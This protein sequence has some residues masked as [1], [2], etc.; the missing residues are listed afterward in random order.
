M[1]PVGPSGAEEAVPGP[2]RAL[3]L[4]AVVLPTLGAL[5]AALVVVGGAWREQQESRREALDAQLAYEANSISLKIRDRIT[6]YGLVLRGAG[7]LFSTERRVTAKGWQNYVERLTLYRDYPGIQGVGFSRMLRPGEVALHEQ[8]MHAEGFANY[9]VWPEGSRE[10]LSAI[11]YL[12]PATAANRRFLGFDMYAASPCSGRPWSERGRVVI[13]HSPEGWRWRGSTMARR[14]PGCC[15][16]FPCM[17]RRSKEWGRSSVGCIA[18]C[19][20]MT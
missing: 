1:N 17:D 8:A 5:M 14:G 16:T 20:W 18:R 7:A 3:G 6:A 11:T 13:W 12:E 10:A 15:C 4:R 2:S 9:R 19:G